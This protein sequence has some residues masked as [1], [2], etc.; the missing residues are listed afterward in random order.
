MLC[1]IGPRF[2]DRRFKAGGSARMCI[3]AD[4]FLPPT[5]GTAAICV[6]HVAI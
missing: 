3:H 5:P 1:E 4:R 6:I 2:F